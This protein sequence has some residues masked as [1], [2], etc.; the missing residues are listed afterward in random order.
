MVRRWL[1][2]SSAISDTILIPIEDHKATEDGA[3][4]ARRL[5]LYNGSDW[6]C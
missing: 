2:S 4:M 5:E 3:D 1:T 6:R